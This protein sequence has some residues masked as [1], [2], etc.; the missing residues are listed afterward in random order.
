MRPSA[1]L[2]HPALLYTDERDFVEGLVPFLREG[3]ENDE[4]LFVAARPDF[5][6]AVRAELGAEASGRW[7][8]TH[9]WHPHHASRLRAFYELI[10][11]APEGTRFRLVGEPVWP[12]RPEHVREWQRYESVLN[13]VLAPYPVSL[14]CLYDAGALD[15]EIVVG[16]RRTHPSATPDSEGEERY[17]EPEEFLLRHPPRS[18]PPPPSAEVVEGVEDLAAARGFVLD[19]A[20]RSGVDPEGAVALGIATNEVVTNAIV[21][22]GGAVRLSVWSADGGFTCQVEDEGRGIADPFAGYRTPRERIGGRGLWIA[23]QLVDLM[24]ILPTERGT[25][26]RLHAR[27]A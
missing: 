11:R 25:T 9:R 13:A 6:A 15:P 4:V 14:L 16:A 1:G 7:E 2:D 3:I 26:V 19:R 17:Q 8:D 24:E 23:R 12:E 22:G 21:H 10:S 5:M 20:V 18:P 27:A